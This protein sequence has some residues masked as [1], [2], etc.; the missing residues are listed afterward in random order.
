MVFDPN[1][2][3]REELSLKPNQRMI[4]VHPARGFLPFRVQT[5]AP[6]YMVYDRILDT[7]G[8]TSIGSNGTIDGIQLFDSINRDTIEV[9]T[10]SLLYHLFLGL[11]PSSLKVFLEYPKGTA[12]RVPDNQNF[13]PTGKFGF[14]DG[15][16]S[17]FDSP[18]PAGEVV[19]PWGRNT[20][21]WRFHNPT[22]LAIT[23]PFI[24]FVGY[25]YQLDVIRN[26]DLV[27]A[28]LEE[29]PGVAARKVPLG[30]L[31]GF[32]YDPREA[33]EADWIPFDWTREDIRAALTTRMLR[34]VA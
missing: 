4:L 32:P 6:F 3:L 33:Y 20:T 28:M 7:A 23:Q 29:R 9:K 27:M 11:T 5:R 19:F 8:V 14:V 21:G 13:T 34:E 17:P 18:T 31:Q 30:G 25:T 26:V 16:Q 2:P 22:T 10:R 15:W 1:Y 12:Q 24:K